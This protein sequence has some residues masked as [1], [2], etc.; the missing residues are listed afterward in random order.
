MTQQKKTGAAAKSKAAAA[1]QE[2]NGQPKT[3]KFE[4]LELVL[5]D[6]IPFKILK[7]LGQGDE[8]GPEEV[9][10]ILNTMLGPEQMEQV[11]NL[12]IDVS[13]GRELVEE[14]LES[15]GMQAGESAASQES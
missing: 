14:V 5:P 10:G 11:W 2:T 3:L 1:R 9:V 13:R 4:G 8:A 6:K 7:Y 15:L 12:D